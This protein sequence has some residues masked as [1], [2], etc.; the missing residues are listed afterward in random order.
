MCLYKA[1][2]DTG[3]LV[4]CTVLQVLKH[5]Y[6]QQTGMHCYQQTASSDNTTTPAFNTQQKSDHKPHEG[7][8]TKLD[9]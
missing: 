7:L 6:S 1:W 5:Y 3:H 2:T 9:Y 4:Y 8:D